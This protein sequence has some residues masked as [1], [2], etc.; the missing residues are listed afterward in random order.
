MRHRG[1]DRGWFLYSEGQNVRPSLFISRG[2]RGSS[3]IFPFVVPTPE[4]SAA[5]PFFSKQKES[6]APPPIATSITNAADLPHHLRHGSKSRQGEG[7]EVGRGAA[8]RGAA[9][10]AGP[11][12]PL[13]R[14]V[15]AEGVLLPLLV[16]GDASAS[17]HKGTPGHRFET[18]SERVSL[19]RAVLLLRALPAFL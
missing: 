14:C 18:G 12:P 7:R 8:A 17:A 16:D 4:I 19:F 1:R 6:S 2:N 10:G 15:G 9:E 3:P 11:L 5:P 13:V